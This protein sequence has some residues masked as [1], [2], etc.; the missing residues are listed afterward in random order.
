[1]KRFAFRLE[2]ILEWRRSRME[3]EQRALE[4]LV[5]ER[6]SLEA[7]QARLEA[8]LEQAR[9]AV[10]QAAAS[11]QALEAETLVALENFSRSVSNE[12][13]V[14]EQRRAEI[15][16][17]IAQQR[18]RLL[19]ARRDLRV[20]EK[21]RERAYRAWERDCARELD[22]LATEAYLARWREPGA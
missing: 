22:A 10:R 7:E 3:E 14:L 2:R 17:R 13:A 11:G 16:R 12:Q 4:R 5:A 20:I 6:A 15:E 9:G 21:L 18:V 19:A 8:A 1:M